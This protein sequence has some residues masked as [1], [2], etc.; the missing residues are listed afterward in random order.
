[1]LTKTKL[2]ATKT[3]RPR[4]R[5]PLVAKDALL[6]AAQELFAEKGFEGA[7][8]RELTRLA[9]CNVAMVSY[10]FGGKDEL[11]Q[12]VIDR[13]FERLR[14]RAARTA[15]SEGEEPRTWS[16]LRDADQRELCRALYGAATFVLS[17]SSMQKILHREA[18]TGGKSIVA[19]LKKNNN[20]V[21]GQVKQSLL[22]LKRAGKLKKDLDVD[23][24]TVSLIGPI[25]YSCTAAA[26]LSQV[27]GVDPKAPDYSAALCLHLTRTFFEGWSS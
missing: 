3:S 14:A 12:A 1:M 15:V 16:Q 11:Y 25:I 6:D 19:A 7:S 18:M 24:G 10:Y 20:G 2:G 17:G 27:Y 5:P 23:L 4:G 9:G 8:M 13:H 26:V 21:F 22:A